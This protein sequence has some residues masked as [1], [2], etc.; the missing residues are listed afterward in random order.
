[1]E[2]DAQGVARTTVYPAHS[3][4]QVDA[5]VA[6]RT[7]HRPVAR[8]EDDR[9]SAIGENHLR[10]GLRSRLLLDEDEFSAFPIAALLAEQ[11]YHLKRKAHFAVEILMKTV[12][13]ARFIMKHQR[14]GLG[15]PSL[16][17]NLQESS[18]VARISK[19]LFTERLRPL[20][21]NFRNMWISAAP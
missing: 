20:I 15:L 7:F 14:C 19:T 18:M 5:V 11:E 4:A 9:L 2:N 6:S 8:G 3:V 10:L 17:T 21:G 16:V 12:I 1:M 13:A